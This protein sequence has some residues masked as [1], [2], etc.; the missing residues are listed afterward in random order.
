MRVG[1]EYYCDRTNNSNNYYIKK[2]KLRYIVYIIIQYSPVCFSANPDLQQSI[3]FV[4]EAYVL[5]SIMINAHKFFADCSVS[6]MTNGKFRGPFMFRHQTQILKHTCSEVNQLFLLIRIFILLIKHRTVYYDA[7]RNIHLQRK[8]LTAVKLSNNRKIR[9]FPCLQR[10][11]RDVDEGSVF[12]EPIQ[13]LRQKKKEYKKKNWKWQSVFNNSKEML[14]LSLN[15]YDS[16]RKLTKQF[17]WQSNRN[18]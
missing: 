10:D 16:K 15:L 12:N 13:I 8:M 3:I 11:F 2:I 1:T 14:R 6:S 5:R 9:C 18:L 4:V 17:P 7:P